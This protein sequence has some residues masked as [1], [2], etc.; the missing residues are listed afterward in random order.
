M[1]EMDQI[2]STQKPTYSAALLP[3]S[4]FEQ[5]MDPTTGPAASA[6]MTPLSPISLHASMA[7]MVD[8]SMQLGFSG[9]GLMGSAVP[10]WHFTESHLEVMARFQAR[11]SLTIGIKQLAPAYRDCVCQLALTVSS[12]GSS[13]A[14]TSRV[15]F[16]WKL[17]YLTIRTATLSSSYAPWSH[18]DARCRYDCATFAGARDTTKTR[19]P[20][21]LEHRNK[22][23][24]SSLDQTHH[25]RLPRCRLGHRNAH[26]CGI[27]LVHELAR[28]R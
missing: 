25:P 21:A 19:R 6:S 26:R 10:Y 22:A 20:A 28:S 27:I 5:R 1:E 12:C 7:T 3:A 18:H 9:V 11:T 14:I 4:H 23:L 16:I 17:S 15:S 13:L 2:G 24:Q 8:S